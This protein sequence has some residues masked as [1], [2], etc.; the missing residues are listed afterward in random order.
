MGG[1]FHQ[2]KPQTP[3]LLISYLCRESSNHSPCAF[4]LMSTAES[5]QPVHA[6]LLALRV[7][8]VSQNGG[9]TKPTWRERVAHTTNR[10]STRE[11]WLGAYD[12][13]W[14]CLP[15]LPFTKSY[16]RR[17]P[18]FYGLDNELPLAL[19]LTTG[20]QHALAMLAGKSGFIRRSIQVRTSYSYRSYHP[21]HCLCEFPKS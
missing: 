10:V 16:N 8:Q 11:G 7:K 2:A 14:L 17:A 13:G 18:P 19:A 9:D 1:N 12:Y 4:P 3:V 15:A 21:A 5:T 20:L 6:T